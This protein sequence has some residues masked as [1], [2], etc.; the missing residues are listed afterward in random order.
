MYP[1]IFGKSKS[2]TRCC[3]GWIGLGKPDITHCPSNTHNMQVPCMNFTL[4]ISLSSMARTF[5]KN[6]SG[7]MFNCNVSTIMVAPSISCLPRICIRKSSG[8]SL[9]CSWAIWVNVFLC[10]LSVS[11]KHGQKPKWTTTLR[12]TFVVFV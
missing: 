8:N 10:I 12:E 1:F 6:S 4:A 9:S 2:E 5:F 7:V 11:V 3:R